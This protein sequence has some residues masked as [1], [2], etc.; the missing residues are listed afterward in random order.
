MTPGFLGS[1]SGI[2]FSTLPTKSAPTSADLVKI[3]PPTLENKATVDAPIPKPCIVDAVAGS[4]PY[5]MY[6]SPKPRRPMAAT[7]RPMIDPPKNATERLS[8]TPEF[9][10][11]VAVLTLALVA[12]YMP[13][14]PVIEELKAPT[15]NATVL[16]SP[17]PMYMPNISISEKTNKIEY[18]FFINAMAP[19]C[20]SS[21]ISVRFLSP[22]G[23][24]FTT[25]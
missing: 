10:A 15:I 13:M 24:F 25:E 2:S 6:N 4:L 1:S 17:S 16:L 19:R 9:C 21:E 23:Y 5:N 3:P 14:K 7:V 12:V 8:L 22:A 20:I 18:S 11:A